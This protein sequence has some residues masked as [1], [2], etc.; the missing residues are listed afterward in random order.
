MQ[1]PPKSN[2]CNYNGVGTVLEQNVSMAPRWFVRKAWNESTYLFLFNTL[3]CCLSPVCHIITCWLSNHS[4]QYSHCRT[5][6]QV[7]GS[8]TGTLSPGIVTLCRAVSFDANNFYTRLNFESTQEHN[9]TPVFHWIYQ[10]I[11][12]LSF[13]RLRP[14]Q[15][16]TY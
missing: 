10:P 4:I 15:L 9:V 5:I 12:F 14:I 6:D 1:I 16:I 3:K 2:P 7:V 11:S 13:D 8:L